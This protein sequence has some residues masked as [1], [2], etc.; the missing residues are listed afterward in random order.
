MISKFA[1]ILLIFKEAGI[2]GRV[3]IYSNTKYKEKYIG[4][5][6]K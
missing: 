5:Y 4:L 1:L 6:G 3:Y 2:G